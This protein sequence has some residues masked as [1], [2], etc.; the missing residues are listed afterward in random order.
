[1]TDSGVSRSDFQD[2]FNQ[3]LMGEVLR[4]KLQL[5]KLNGDG[6]DEMA[7]EIARFLNGFIGV[8]PEEHREHLREQFLNGMRENPPES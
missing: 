8:F 2:A 3:L 1:M 6:P 7:D 5:A 4:M